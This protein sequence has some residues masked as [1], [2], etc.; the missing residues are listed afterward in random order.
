MHSKDSGK[1]IKN[2]ISVDFKVPSTFEDNIECINETFTA[3]DKPYSTFGAS[4]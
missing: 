1:L 2:M 4:A 3:G